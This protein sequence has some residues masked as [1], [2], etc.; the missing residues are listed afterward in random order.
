MYAHNNFQVSQPLLHW[1]PEEDA[2]MRTLTI[3]FN[4][5]WA[6]IRANATPGERPQKDKVRLQF[7][8]S[9]AGEHFAKHHKLRTARAIVSRMV[10]LARPPQD[11]RKLTITA[12]Q[13]ENLGLRY[14]LLCDAIDNLIGARASYEELL[15]EMKIPGFDELR[16]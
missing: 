7:A 14:E 5:H 4:E 10:H 16:P 2:D 1:T 12:D 15:R 13:A 8:E 9:K 3:A 6:T 11:R